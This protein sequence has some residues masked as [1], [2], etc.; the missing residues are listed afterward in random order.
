MLS[1][2]EF[3]QWCERLQ[4]GEAARQYIESVRYS[5][6]AR[7]VTSNGKGN[8]CTAVASQ[9]MG[10]TINTE[11]RTAEFVFAREFEFDENVLEFWDQPQPVPVLRHRSSK[12]RWETY[13]PDYLVLWK[14][15]VAVFEVKKQEHL[16]DLVKKTPEDWI[17]EGMNA[18]FRPATVA[19]KALGLP[20]RVLVA[21]PGHVLRG[22]NLT[23]L[24][25]ARRNGED[26]TD[27]QR[28]SVSKT[29]EEQSCITLA[30]LTRKLK[31]EDHTPLLKA[32]ATGDL[33]ARLETDELA[34]PST[35]WLARQREYLSALPL[36]AT[37][38]SLGQRTAGVVIPSEACLRRL[39][40]RQERLKGELPDRTARRLKALIR[41][42]QL[43]GRTVGECLLP[44][45]DR[46]GD[47]RPRLAAVQ[48][49]V[50]NESIVRFFASPRRV[51]KSKAFQQYMVAAADRHPE[52]RAV[53]WWTYRELIARFDPKELADGRGGRRAANSAAGPSPVE[54]REPKPLRPFERACIDHCLIPLDIVIFERGKNRITHKAWVTMMVDVATG[55]ILAV[56]LSLHPPSCSAD[57]MVVRRCVEA[58]GLFPEHIQ[59]DR[60]SDF[61]SLFFRALLAYIGSDHSLSPPASSRTNSSVER[62]FGHMLLE[63]VQQRPGNSV[64]GESPRGISGT[65]S[66]HVTSELTIR[67][68]WHELQLFVE[69]MNNRSTDLSGKS[70][71]DKLREGLAQFKCS[72]IK[73]RM[74]PEFRISSAVDIRDYKLDSKDGIRVDDRRYSCAALADRRPATRPIKVRIEPENP[75]VVY[76][77][78]N[79]AWH[80]CHATQYSRFE[81][82]EALEKLAEATR[83]L[84]GASL[85]REVRAQ[86]QREFIR[87]L[88]QCDEDRAARKET[89]SYASPEQLDLPVAR[90]LFDEV[91][92]ES[93]DAPTEQTQEVPEHALDRLRNR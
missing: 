91:R 46:C 69:W 29:F 84:D 59:T 81:N 55:Y 32:I 65:H 43:E 40:G 50:A 78:I 89:Q 53:S 54:S 31:L 22:V 83:V 86:A 15:A 49:E 66:P 73:V 77:E 44:R 28:R 11:S 4:L 48:L 30:D 52:Y 9:N 3:T 90:N 71:A 36:P 19:F 87:T 7:A 64:H 21:G 47:R 42:G 2:L 37:P 33:F 5:D 10:V 51:S 72:G 70:A 17:T 18:E 13:T 1:D 16:P 23:L 25:Q 85:K 26:L 67:D 45:F 56:W 24:L 93:V 57:A 6:P 74:T 75:Y 68:A 14:D 82:Q 41:D 76:A 63:W 88:N 27:S 38:G 58:F 60:G 92:A 12:A 79:G 8:I 34:R 80:D 61:W 35:A 39:L 20:F 62:Q